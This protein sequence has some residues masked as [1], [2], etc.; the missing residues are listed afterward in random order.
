MHLYDGY[1]AVGTFARFPGL[2]IRIKEIQWP[3]IDGGGPI[4]T[5][6]MH[7]RTMRTNAP[8]ALLTIGMIKMTVQYDPSIWA[9]LVTAALVAG[10][11]NPATGVNS[12]GVINVPTAMTLTA[13]DGATLGLFVYINKFTPAPFKEGELPLAD[14]EIVPTNTNWAVPVL[15]QAAHD[16]IPSAAAGI[17]PGSVVA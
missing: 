5:T 10:L 4:D 1:R 6:V 16:V 9:S 12:V 2:E 3:E 11:R 8:K 14:L 7:N 15:A 17:L 13:P